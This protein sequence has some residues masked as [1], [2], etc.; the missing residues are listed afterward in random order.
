MSPGWIDGMILRVHFETI[1]FFERLDWTILIFSDTNLQG[2][3]L[4]LLAIPLDDLGK[5]SKDVQY[6]KLASTK[7]HLH[8]LRPLQLE[9]A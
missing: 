7:Y 6:W 9:F 4:T 1:Q 2:I 3:A 8:V 5:K